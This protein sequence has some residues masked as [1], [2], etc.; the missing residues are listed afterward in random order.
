MIGKAY[1]SYSDIQKGYSDSGDLDD[2][3]ITPGYALYIG[4]KIFS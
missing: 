3:K 4:S 2:E 1:F